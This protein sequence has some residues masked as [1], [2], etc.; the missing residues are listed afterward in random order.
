M[1]STHRLRSH[2]ALLVAVAS[3]WLGAIGTAAADG[4]D[5]A[6]NSCFE[7]NLAAGGCSAPQ[8][9]EFV[10]TVEP[11]CCDVAWDELCVA[12]AAKFCSPCGI[13]TTSCFGPQATPGCVASRCC[14]YICSIPG[15][16][17]CCEVAWDQAC[18][19]AA[20][21]FCQGCGAPGNE[22]C[23]SVHEA[24]GCEDAECCELV[25]AVDPSCCTLGWDQICVQW[26]SIF[27]PGCGGPTAGSCCF[28][29]PGPFC[30]DA[31]CC[32]TVCDIDP[33][34]CETRWDKTC[35]QFANALCDLPNCLCGDPAAGNCKEVHPNPGCA[36]FDCCNAVCE[37]DPFCCIVTWDFACT[38][39][40]EQLCSINPACGNPGSGSCFVRH[41][42]PGCEDAGCCGRVCTFDPLCCELIWDQDC[43]DLAVSICTDCGDTLAGSCFAPN[44]TPACSDLACCESVCTIDAFCCEFAWDSVCANFA[45][46]VCAEPIGACGGPLGRSCYTPSYL[47]G[48]DD[49]GCC[50]TICTTVDPFCCE[51]RWDAVCAQLAFSYCGA[52]SGCPGRGSC[53][54]PKAFPGCNDPV[55]CSA[56]CDLDPLCCQLSWD[57]HCANFAKGICFGLDNCPGPLPCNRSHLSPG[58]EDP[59]CCNVVCAT[60]PFCCIEA[61]DSNCVQIA[62]ARCRPGPDSNCPCAGSCF[63]S[64]ANPG[65]EDP[66]C[67]AGVCFIDPN[68]C[69]VGWDD[70]CVAIARNVCCGDVGC[71]DWCAG[72][73]FTPSEKPFCNDAACCEAVCTIDPFCCSTRWDGICISLAVERCTGLCGIVGAGSCFSPRETPACE[74]QI[75]CIAVCA[76]D[77]FCCE[78]QWDAECATMAL[79]DPKAD[80]PKAGL[81]EVPSCG[82]FRAG[83]CCIAHDGPACADKT[84]CD[85]V[86]AIDPVCC[87]ATW[88]EV[89]VGIARGIPD[90]NCVAECGD[91]C[92]GSCCEARLTPLCDDAK[93]CEA[94]CAVDPF[95]CQLDGG[96]WDV[97][98]VSIAL[99]QPECQDPCPS[100]ECGDPKAL[101]CCSAH[102]GANCDDAEC[103]EEVCD[104]DPFCCDAQWDITCAAIAAKLCDVCQAKFFCGAPAAGDCFEPSST[105]FCDDFGCCS[106]ICTIDDA[107]CTTAWDETCAK[108]ASQF[109]FP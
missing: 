72:S 89:C 34:C 78:S 106:L 9:C 33:F 25:C 43:A 13:S 52:A 95:C 85:E 27:C 4:C 2:L 63:E 75:C 93:C 23:S 56:I 35:V 105:P 103:C 108:L 21:E 109:C 102:F 90:C 41:P 73:C 69:S 104:L 65:C 48:C 22:R 60:D 24:P 57:V 46:A 51:V 11:A 82:Q 17:F 19:L 40:T 26:A 88:D 77:P 92:A 16:D 8:C 70:A 97:V 28:N 42:T 66:S 38:R 67:C 3:A 7:V 99:T 58:C 76:A 55:C 79:G 98:C 39:A 14:E 15:F 49:P 50:F 71:G 86:C 53:L 20:K 37:V 31:A 87:D 64:H 29:Q 84:C 101:S 1:P 47:P 96:A 32:E 68:C 62:N 10:C 44:G 12:L 18:V 94:V 45:Q 74:D 107:C 83:R 61:W 5:G 100:P 30:D 36:D 80:P 59:A 54:V 91:V 6:T 81:C